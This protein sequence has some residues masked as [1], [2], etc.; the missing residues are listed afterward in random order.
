MKALVQMFT[1]GEGTY[2]IAVTD[3]D[4]D[5]MFWLFSWGDLVTQTNT[6]Y[7]S[8][9]N[10]DDAFLLWGADPLTGWRHDGVPIVTNVPCILECE[11]EAAWT[12]RA[13]KAMEEYVM[14]RLMPM[15]LYERIIG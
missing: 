6:S 10:C 15:A 5:G 2:F 3:A 11:D 9:R 14:A 13:T 7:K 4:D 8:A 1:N 12:Q